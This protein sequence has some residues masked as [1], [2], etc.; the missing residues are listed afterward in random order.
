MG[1]AHGQ[2]AVGTCFSG[3]VALGMAADPVVKAP[4]LSQP[5]G[6][7]AVGRDRRQAIH[8]SEEDAAAVIANGCQV[9]GLRFTGD[10]SVPADRFATLRDTLG[11]RFIPLEIESPDRSL[12]IKRSAYSVLTEDLIDV[13]G[14]PPHAALAQVLTSSK[15]SF[16]ESDSTRLDLDICCDREDDGHRTQHQAEKNG[17]RRERESTHGIG[18]QSG[19]VVT[20]GSSSP[21]AVSRETP[22]CCVADDTLPDFCRGGSA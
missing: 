22:A 20:G 17:G 3:G 12:S 14:Y 21:R 13:P 6:P 8:D 9:M 10:L 4:A 19:S 18:F 15:N 7:F 16:P 11:D 2:L 1:A 5:A